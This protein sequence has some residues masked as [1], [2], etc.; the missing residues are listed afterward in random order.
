M[1]TS[2]TWIKHPVHNIMV[3]SVY[4][5]LVHPDGQPVKTFRERRTGHIKAVI[6]SRKVNKAA[7]TLARVVMEAT[8]GK[9]LPREVWVQHKDRYKWNF[10][11]S[12]L[13]LTNRAEFT[14]RFFV[15]NR[16]I[17]LNNSLSQTAFLLLQETGTKDYDVVGHMFQVSGGEI[18]LLSK[19]R[20][21]GYIPE[22]LSVTPEIIRNKVE[23]FKTTEAL[24]LGRDEYLRKEMIRGAQEYPQ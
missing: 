23:E 9:P 7:A 13:F 8:I 11:P 3:H 17:R 16:W 19:K 24:F 20:A 14:K 18:Y 2:N 4:G 6:S 10:N 12:N 15:D 1:E 5:F 22:F 21:W